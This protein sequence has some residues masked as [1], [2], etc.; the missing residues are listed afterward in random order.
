MPSAFWYYILMVVSVAILAIVLIC[1]KDFR[2]LVLHLALTGIIHP[3]EIAVMIILVGYRYLPG[4]LPQPDHDNA[5][6]AFVSDLFIVP[7]SAVVINAFSLGWGAITGFAAG[8]TVIDW[9]YAKIGVYEHY[10]WKSVYTG[11][12]LLIFYAISRKLWAGLCEAR[13]ARWFR[14][15]V[16][17]LVYSTLHSLANM[18]TVMIFNLYRFQAAWVEG[19]PARDHAASHTP[20]LYSV[21]AIVA[22]ST[23]LKLKFRY[24]LAG[25]ALIAL[26]NWG[27]GYYEVFVPQIITSSHYLNVIPPLIIAVMTLLF[28]AAKLDYL[29]P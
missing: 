1:K 20:F 28:R 23:G 8:F 7:A 29:F 13:P 15:A 25:F 26:M 22:L 17:Y 2:L 6:G 3:F 24:R 21:S 27:V 11:I 16:I 9:Y 10:W 4:I 19:G 5:F 12:G 18:F 14:L